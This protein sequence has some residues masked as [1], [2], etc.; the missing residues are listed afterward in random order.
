MNTKRKTS[1]LMVSLP[2]TEKAQYF[3]GG[4]HEL[5]EPLGEKKLKLSD[6]C[7]LLDTL[8]GFPYVLKVMQYFQRV[9]EKEP[10][11]VCVSELGD[12]PLTTFRPPLQAIQWLDSREIQYVKTEA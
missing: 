12:S 8:E 5:L 11:F 1:I 9:A 10:I 2:W 6:T 3:F 7:Y 4:Y